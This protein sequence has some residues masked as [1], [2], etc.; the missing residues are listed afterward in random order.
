MAALGSGGYAR[1]DEVE[2]LSSVM[3]GV[4]ARRGQSSPPPAPALC[5]RRRTRLPAAP[6]DTVQ[7]RVSLEKVLGITA[8]NSSG[9][10]CDPST[11]HVAYLAG[12]VVVILD[13]KENKQQ[14]IFNTAR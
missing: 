8:Q 5:H 7:N 3:A 13:P 4:P 9:L 2:K 10:T 12:C 6:E 11:G 14:H 1:N